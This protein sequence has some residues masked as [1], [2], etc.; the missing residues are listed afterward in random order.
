MITP[1]MIVRQ[2]NRS[3]NHDS[4]MISVHQEPL[5]NPDDPITQVSL[6]NPTDANEAETAKLQLA[7]NS[8]TVQMAR[9]L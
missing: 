2:I 7:K 6:G 5:H 1:S 9:S 3:V 4:H 8:T